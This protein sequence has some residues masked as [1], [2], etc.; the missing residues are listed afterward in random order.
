MS[1]EGGT[2]DN[3]AGNLSSRG[4]MTL[5]LLAAL[6]N[7]NGK[8]ASGGA[9][10]PRRS[11]QIND[12]GGQLVSKSLLTLNTAGQLDNSNRGTLASN[13]TLHIIAAGNVVNTTD[14]LIY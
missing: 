6:T 5:D 13:G 1:F 11:T 12:Q 8:L 10:L 2:L 14:G 3:S 9:L 4:A 7:T